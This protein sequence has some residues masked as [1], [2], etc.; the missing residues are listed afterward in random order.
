[1]AE[2]G[3]DGTGSDPCQTNQPDSS[4]GTA[5]E[6]GEKNAAGTIHE[7]ISSGMFALDAYPGVGDDEKLDRVY[8]SLVQERRCQ[9]S[10]TAAEA[11]MPRL[12]LAQ[13]SRTQEPYISVSR[14]SD[15]ADSLDIRFFARTFPTLFPFGEG[16]PCRAGEDAEDTNEGAAANL[17]GESAA[18][19]LVLSRTMTL[20]AWARAVLRRHGGRFATHHIF[21]FL[22]FNINVR[23]RNR[24]V[25]MLS[26][27]RKDFPEVERIARSLS[28]ERL[29]KA[30]A[31]LE[32]TRQ[33]TDKDVNRLLR[34]LSLYGARQPMSRESRRTMRRKIKSLIIRYGA[35]AIWFT[36]NPNDITNPVKLRLAAHRY[37]DPEEAE[38]FLA[39]LDLAYKRTK[40][41]ISDPLS[42]AVF[43]HREISLFFE[44]YVKVGEDSVFGRI[45]QYFGAVETNER[46][47]LHIHGLLW[48]QGNLNLSSILEDVQE[49]GRAQYR[50]RIIQYVDSIF[51]EVRSLQY[52]APILDMPCITAVAQ[53]LDEEAFVATQAE[54]SITSDVSSLLQNTDAI[55]AAFEEEANFC[56]GSSQ[57]HTHTPSC[58]KYS[59]GKQGGNRD[60]CRF[61]APWRLVERTAFSPDGVLHIRRNHSLVNRWNKAIAVGLRHNRDISFVATQCKTM[62][63][64]YYVTNYAT[65]VEDP[66]WKR[67]AAAADVLG[68][69]G[70]SAKG[71]Q[72]KASYEEDDPRLNK[73]RQLMMRIAN[74]VF[75]DRTLSQVEVVSHLLG[76]PSEFT[77]VEAWTFLHVSSLYWHIFR[78]WSHLRAGATGIENVEDDAGEK[79]LLEEAG[80]RASFVQAYPHRGRLLQHLSLY[81]Y[82]S[83]VRLKRK[84]SD[85]NRWNTFEFDSDWPLSSTWEQVLRRP[86]RHAAVCFD[87]YLSMNFEEEEQPFHR[88]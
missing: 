54:R 19:W 65:K 83:I 29:H 30:R 34:S 57:V 73:T 3:E 27:S 63:L 87:G 9:R 26:V 64:V 15:F 44:H 50:E 18:R 84:K 8:E 37:Q 51:T 70:K 80:Q 88:R 13:H 10:E 61:K 59:V 35:P 38:A 24:R 36:L 12:S 32:A 17:E 85:E 79:V 49:Q 55:T 48:L 46:G 4:A 42:S 6:N 33:T 28:M 75:T 39:S 52:E 20:E 72:A 60:L 43:F 45:S 78:R 58:V 16:G 5:G 82:A 2:L 81:D 71:E 62:A 25:S 40:L 11:Q 7:I 53:D 23:S 21:A 68:G 22:V 66:V 86:G 67:V 1:M 56:A 69:F 41:A 77:N 76:Y 31:E 47:A 74:R 14:G